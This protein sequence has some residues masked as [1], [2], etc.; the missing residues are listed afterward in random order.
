M[1][2]FPDKSI[3]PVSRAL[4]HP[5]KK[6]ARMAVSEVY[7]DGKLQK[8]EFIDEDEKSFG[9]FMHSLILSNYVEVMKVNNTQVNLIGDEYEKAIFRYTEEKG[10]NKGLIESIA[11]KVEEIKYNNNLRASTHLINEQTRIISKG[12][13]E[14]L[15][16]RCSYILMD[17]RF[18]K[19]TRRVF[20]E[21]NEVLKDMLKRCINV[22]AIAIKDV[23]KNPKIFKMDRFVDDMA[24]V[25]LVGMEM[26]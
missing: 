22:Y 25:A 1:E 16:R 17:S 6:A 2:V 12:T 3:V 4:V 8:A 15:L 9:I 5:P 14:E 10:F 19:I 7:L 23:S 13:P 26:G 24:L 18:V 20:G 11:P 21:V